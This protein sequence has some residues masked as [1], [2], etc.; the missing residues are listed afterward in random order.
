MDEPSWQVLLIGG[1]SGTGK[2]TIAS[3]IAK[4]EQISH[5]LVDDIRMALQATITAAQQPDLH[6]FLTLNDLASLP[7]ERF[8]EGFMRVGNALAP[9]L[10]AIVS[11]H[12]AVPSAGRLIIEGDGILPTTI[13]TMQLTGLNGQADLKLREKLRTIFLVED[14]ENALLANFIRRDRGFNQAVNEVQRRYVNSI[15]HFGQW[16]SASARQYKQPVVQVRPFETLQQRILD[17]INQNEEQV[18]EYNLSI[19]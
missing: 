13:A 5:L 4:S 19:S 12:L 16:I 8:I 10:E 6:Y 18:I 15:W 3:Q 17:S 2:T 11:H 1:S 9:A 7:A 14:D